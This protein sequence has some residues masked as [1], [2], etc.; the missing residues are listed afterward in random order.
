MKL[1]ETFLIGG[2]KLISSIIKIEV[3][4]FVA[5]SN[6]VKIKRKNIVI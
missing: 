4:G 5:I 1:L 2:I 6:S 3:L